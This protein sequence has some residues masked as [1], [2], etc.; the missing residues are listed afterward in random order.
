MSTPSPATQSNANLDDWLKRLLLATVSGCLPVTLAS[1][2]AL[3]GSLVGSYLTVW[4]YRPQIEEIQRRQEMQEAADWEE[5]LVY[6]LVADAGHKGE[7]INNLYDDY[8]KAAKKAARQGTVTRK[9]LGKDEFKRVLMK[10]T[11]M[12][13][14]T[15]VGTT[16][17]RILG[18]SDL[19]GCG[20]AAA[21]IIN[22][23]T[24]KA[25]TYLT[26]NNGK[27]DA[28]QV[29]EKFQTDQNFQTESGEHIGSGEA[30]LLFMHLFTGRYIGVDDADKIWNFGARFDKIGSC[31]T[32]TWPIPAVVRPKP[33]PDDRFM[34][35]QYDPGPPRDPLPRLDRGFTPKPPPITAPRGS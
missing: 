34:P 30:Q 32:G 6:S 35:R 25:L 5:P 3:V 27:L 13:V 19:C 7:T 4:A 22:Q 10:L 14:I 29:I 18:E 26:E 21:E 2:L 11:S 8:S 28:S 24:P 23:L 15:P 31:R 20:Y 33:V 17:Y 16:K 9:V 1:I 12:R